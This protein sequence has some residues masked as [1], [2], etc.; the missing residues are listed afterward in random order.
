MKGTLRSGCF[1]LGDK[2]WLLAP[3]DYAGSDIYMPQDGA[4][5]GGLSRSRPGHFVEWVNAIKGGG[6][7]VELP[8]LCRR[9]RPRRCCWA[10]WPCGPLPAIK[11]RPSEAQKVKRRARQEDRMWDAKNLTATNAPEVAHIVKPEF[12]NGYKL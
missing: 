6:R 4:A 9:P 11:T 8:R 1:V 2:G 12:H 10:T 5:E 3:G 7:D